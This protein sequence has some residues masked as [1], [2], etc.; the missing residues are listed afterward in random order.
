MAFTA[1]GKGKEFR[2]QLAFCLNTN[3]SCMLKCLI[4]NN[5]SYQ[6]ATDPYSESDSFCSGTKIVLKKN[7][8]LTFVR[9]RFDARNEIDVKDFLELSENDAFSLTSN[10]YSATRTRNY[11]GLQAEDVSYFVL[12]TNSKPDE[13]LLTYFKIDETGELYKLLDSGRCKVYQFCLDE[14][15][16][17]ELKLM[18]NKHLV[19]AVYVE[20][21]RVESI[22][23]ETRRSLEAACPSE[24]ISFPCLLSIL[25]RCV[26]EFTSKTMDHINAAVKS[27]T[28]LKDPAQL[29]SLAH[30]ET[31]LAS[32]RLS[33]QQHPADLEGLRLLVDVLFK[34]YQPRLPEN[35]LK[36]LYSTSFVGS[37]D[38]CMNR[39][40]E[41][42]EF[43]DVAWL[44][45]KIQWFL[46]NNDEEEKEE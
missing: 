27:V 42:L 39:P 13:R 41:P 37:W 16:K 43:H 28:E 30:F 45:N 29:D 3:L 44:K 20:L 32:F 25:K 7:D 8:K 22:C 33:Y 9:T 18:I 19:L 40:D 14:S 23:E 34:K 38:W 46:P 31:F 21:Y 36:Y 1:S 10:F 12:H 2:T 5:D 17:N 4:E 26:P 24:S 11:Q 15:K 6:F 35:C